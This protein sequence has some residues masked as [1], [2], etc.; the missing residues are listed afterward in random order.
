VDLQCNPENFS[1]FLHAGPRSCVNV[2][3]INK[4]FMLGGEWKIADF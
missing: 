1:S 2:S 4:L 3:S